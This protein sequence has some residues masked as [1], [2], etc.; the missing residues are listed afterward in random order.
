MA[1]WFSA[2]R[3]LK[4]GGAPY[5]FWLFLAAAIFLCPLEKRRHWE[6]RAAACALAFMALG[7]L[8]PSNRLDGNLLVVILWYVIAWLLISLQCWCIC[9]ISPEEAFFCGINAVLTEH[10]GSSAHILLTIWLFKG[11][12]ER[13]NSFSMLAYVVVYIVIL[14]TFG[15][16][17]VQGKRHLRVNRWSVAIVTVTGLAVTVVLSMLLK[18]HIDPDGV[19]AL[20]DPHSVALLE[21]GQWYAIFFCVSILVLQYVQ[22][23]ELIASE[24]L[25]SIHELWSIREKQYEMSRETIDMINRKCH[26]MKHQ[27]AALMSGED[28]GGRKARYA[29]EVEQLIEIYDLRMHTKNEALNT[30]LMEKG[31]FCSMQGIQWSCIVDDSSLDFIDRMDLYVLLGNALDNAIEAVQRIEDETN[32]VIQLQ[33]CRKNSFIHIRLENSYEGRLEWKGSL[34][35]TTKED[36]ASHGIGLESI[37]SIAEK[38]G[39]Y[40]SASTENQA[41]ILIVLIPIP[42]K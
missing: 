28:S 13:L 27:I 4:T 14:L 25:A 42:S 35:V 36:K 15:R 38:Y 18:S 41:F 20:A 37:C 5:C 7:W 29:R 2:I 33:I 30:I 34:P 9:R 39:G 19:F 16:R 17:M 40:A 21:T 1:D 12:M 24:K 10:I 23:R 3:E 31:L 32:R 11:Q 6:I 22:Q 26:D 8:F